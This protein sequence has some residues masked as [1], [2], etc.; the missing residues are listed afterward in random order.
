MTTFI[1]AH[2]NQN[3]YLY[4]YAY[5]RHL[6]IFKSLPH[7]PTAIS[8]HHSLIH[9]FLL[10]TSRSDSEIKISVSKEQDVPNF[11]MSS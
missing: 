3:T 2:Y 1:Q 8:V 6:K 9:T 10:A 4:M 11:T 5:I 7:T